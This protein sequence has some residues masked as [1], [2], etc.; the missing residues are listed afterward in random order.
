[1]KAIMIQRANGGGGEWEIAPSGERPFQISLREGKR[2]EDIEGLVHHGGPGGAEP[3][4]QVY[5][6][7][8]GGLMVRVS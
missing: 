3:W 5:E 6:D 8:Y 1:M 4:G 7:K 2:R